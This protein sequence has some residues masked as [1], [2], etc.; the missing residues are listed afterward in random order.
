MHNNQDFV[1]DNPAFVVKNV[2]IDPDNYLISKNNNVIQE[3][4]LQP[5]Q[6]PAIAKITVSPNPVNSIALV[7]IEN[8]QGKFN[9]NYSTI[10]AMCYGL[11]RSKYRKDR[12]KFKYPFPLL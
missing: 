12:H 5:T 9:C 7:Q 10:Q 3:K 4:N 11:N 2:V 1:I 6:M 8:L